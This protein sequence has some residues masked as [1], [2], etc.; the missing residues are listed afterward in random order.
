MNILGIDIGTTT[1][2]ALVLDTETKNVI[3]NCTLANDTFI[4]GKAFEKLQ[5]AN[6]IIDIVKKA[7]TTVTDGIKIDAVGVARQFLV[8]P[9][10]ITKMIE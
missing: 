9:E 2:T 10:W 7:V 3:K 8:D 4:D 1:V 6:K 5:D